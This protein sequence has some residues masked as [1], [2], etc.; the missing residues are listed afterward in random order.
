V[1]KQ[2]YQMNQPFVKPENLYSRS[3]PYG[4]LF[5]IVFKPGLYFGINLNF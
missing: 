4:G 2:D 1:L 3:D 5:E